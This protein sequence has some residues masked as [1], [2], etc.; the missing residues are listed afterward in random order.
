MSDLFKGKYR[1][2]TSFAV[3]YPLLPSLTVQPR[4]IDLYQKQF[5]HD[6][7]TLEYTAV[8]ALWFNSLKTGVAVSFSWTQDGLTRYWVGY[9]N[10]VTKIESTN[11]LNPMTVMCVGTSFVF[12][13]R[14]T[15]VFA[16]STITAAVETLAIENGFNYIGDADST[17]FEQL[18]IP[19]S[20]QWTWIQEQAQKIGYGVVIDG[21]NFIF[22]PIDKL[23]DQSFSNTTI[24]S[25]GDKTLPFNAQFL[26]RTLDMITVI[27]GDNVETTSD[28]RAIKTVGGVDPITSQ[29]FISKS[30]PAET[31]VNLRTNV[32]GVLF[33]EYRTDRVVHSQ[34]MADV[35]ASGAATLA[36]FNLP[37][38]AKAQGD[39]S[40]RPFSTVFITGTGD[41][42]DGYW[43]VKEA[44]HMIHAVGD[45]MVELSLATDGS[46]EENLSPFRERGATLV[47]T[48]NISESLS[49]YGGKPFYFDMSSVELSPSTVPTTQA[50]TIS[51]ARWQAVRKAGS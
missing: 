44:R 23:I 12:K 15:R 51:Q 4:R 14:T 39:P 28:N 36:R 41:K 32:S 24:L 47:G 16:N 49:K 45:Y 27:S 46:G 42:T 22:R 25:M 33:T 7:V 30:S 26:D 48:I 20:S 5:T 9:V 13:E 17:V 50:G 21:P 2:G 40:I 34:V 1:K 37:A 43:F 35:T 11:R 38:K 19:G 8:S 6:I 29:A 18:T 3:S 10:T 31:G